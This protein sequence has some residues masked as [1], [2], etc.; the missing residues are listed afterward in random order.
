MTLRRWLVLGR[1]SNLPTVWA[2]VLCAWLLAGGHSCVEFLLSVS[3]ISAIYLGGMFLNDYRDREFDR[4]HRPG[5]PI[6][7]GGAR[8]RTVL[9]WAI[10]LLGSGMLLSLAL[11]LV[12]SGLA[13]F[14]ILLVVAY[15]VVHKKVVWAPFLMAA[16]RLMVFLVVAFAAGGG[17]S[18]AVCAA[19]LGM[20]GYIAGLS[21]AARNSMD[22]GAA[23]RGG[24]SVPARD[25]SGWRLEETPTRGEQR[26][27][28]ST[29]GRSWPG[30][31]LLAPAGAGI[32]GS[33][34]MLTPAAWWA[35]AG[36]L[37]WTGRSLL[38]LY[39][40]RPPRIDRA[41]SGLLAGIALA[42]LYLA[43]S[44]GQGT[45]GILLVFLALWATSHLAQR[46]IPAN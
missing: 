3:A 24:S 17:F 28:R 12:A 45:S 42:D 14:L 39:A 5:R 11:G 2:D 38:D 22:R 18:G 7:S 41:V 27:T 46:A 26:I 43:A 33:G 9:T 30:V 40:S 10:G 23:T 21:L 32:L 4:I 31:L 36:L 20:F 6:P 34:A 37:L 19:A 16:C 44:L 15:D 25:G 1:V 8:P 35:L 13:A 29:S